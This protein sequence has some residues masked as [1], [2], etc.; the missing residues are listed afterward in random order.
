MEPST[1][2]HVQTKQW[3]VFYF[4]FSRRFSPSFRPDSFYHD[5]LVTVSHDRPSTHSGT[6]CPPP[7]PPPPRA[8][9]RAALI[10]NKL[11]LGFSYGFPNNNTDRTWSRRRRRLTAR[12]E[13]VTAGTYA[14]LSSPRGSG[15]IDGGRDPFALCLSPAPALSLPNSRR[16]T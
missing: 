7:P 5:T 8:P 13:V 14:E 1:K 12:A 6:A 4:I 10:V 3:Y 15:P 9:T 11:L 2:Y 16:T